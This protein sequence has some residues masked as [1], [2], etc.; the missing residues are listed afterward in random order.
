MPSLVIRASNSFLANCQTLPPLFGPSWFSQVQ[1]GNGAGLFPEPIGL[2]QP[3]WPLQEFCPGVDCTSADPHPQPPCPAQVF[4]PEQVC[5]TAVAQVP[6][7]AMSPEPPA[8][9]PL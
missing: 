7:P 5:G 8:P 6:V 3:P 9:W 4:V 1:F 2:P